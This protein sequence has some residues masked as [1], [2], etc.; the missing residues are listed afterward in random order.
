LLC[1]HVLA[2]IVDLALELWQVVALLGPVEVL[3]SIARHFSFSSCPLEH[4]IF[5]FQDYVH[6]YKV[7]IA[8]CQR[9]AFSELVYHTHNPV[10]HGRI[11]FSECNVLFFD[12]FIDDS[13]TIRRRDLVQGLFDVVLVTSKFMHLLF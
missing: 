4:S 5:R 10:F 6:T 8:A 13:A 12:K 7:F 3:K 11:V 9:V 1:W 2:L